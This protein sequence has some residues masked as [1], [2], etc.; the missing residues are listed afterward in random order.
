VISKEK[1]LQ[2]K[3]G[4]WNSYGFSLNLA[5]KKFVSVFLPKDVHGVNMLIVTWCKTFISY[6]G[7]MRIKQPFQQNYLKIEK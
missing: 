3:I 7:Q 1:W 4:N 6:G 2:K 5:S